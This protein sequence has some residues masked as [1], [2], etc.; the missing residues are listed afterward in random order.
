LARLSV[1]VLEDRTLLSNFVVDRLTDTGDGMGLTGDLRYCITNAVDG[2]HV[3]FADGVTGTIN[4]TGAL[5]DL[6]H[7][8]SIDGPGVASLTV[9]RDT[10][11][12]YRIFTVDSGT[13][14][15]LAGLTIANGFSYSWGGG[16]LNSG[17]LTLTNATVSGNSGAVGGGVSNTS[18]GTLTLTNVII[19][20]N[21]GDSPAVYGAGIT[22]YGTA[23]LTNATVN[24]NTGPGI[25][26]GGTVTV[27]NSTFSGNGGTGIAI[28]G[29][30]TNCTISG[31]GGAGIGLNGTVTNC[32]ISGNAGPGIAINGTV[33]DCTISGNG[34]LYLGGGG[35]VID[36][37]ATVTDCTISGNGNLYLGGGI[38]IYSGAT[39]TLNNSTVRG[40]MVGPVDDISGYG[41][42]IANWGSLTLNNSTVSGNTSLDTIN[43]E[44]AGGGIFNGGGTV[45][46]NN[47]TVSGN[48][49]L[50]NLDVSGYG[51]GIWNGA[52]T[53]TLNNSTVSGN[54]AY[55]GG[56]IFNSTR[57]SP[58]SGASG[59]AT[60]TLNNTTVSGNTG[61]IGNDGEGN[62]NATVTLLNS[63]ISGNQGPGVTNSA[64]FSD[65][66][67]TVVL[68]NSTICGNDAIGGRGAGG[69]A[70]VVYYADATVVLLNSTIAN[71]TISSSDRTGSQ[72]YSGQLAP[73][74]GQASVQLRNTLVAGSGPRPTL[75]A[76]I[77]GTFI[78]QGHNLSNDDGS[79]FLTGPGDV[80]NT[81]PL[82]GPLQDNG[83]P[84]QTMA[85]LPGSPAIDA[86]DDT[87]PLP[88]F[89]QRGPGFPR[90]SGPHIDIGAFEVQQGGDAGGLASPGGRASGRLRPDGAVR[91][92]LALS[93]RQPLSVS[94]S[95]PIAQPQGTLPGPAAASADRFF[96]ALH[97]EKSAVMSVRWSHREPGEP[98][99]WL[100]DPLREEDCL[101]V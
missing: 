57:I 91:L 63:T 60:L 64:S 30:V 62:Y 43:D 50:F 80:I 26:G 90:L 87:P 14:V 33:T 95:P 83:G 65:A 29:T 2:D 92:S 4:L 86:G 25:E 55:S 56:G 5:P 22:T 36:G 7:S 74:P 70:N 11:G 49:I 31:N 45:T 19:S 53:V 28:N 94:P 46:L 38:S 21:M 85:L 84:T 59:P 35:I 81:N 47:S 32:M 24:G 58:A 69:I 72:I 39:L 76:D 41:A 17:T 37:T 34:G 66:T 67:T 20:N 82:L 96:A 93:L 27:N 8:I 68:L 6:S 75:F 73:G 15:S 44:G 52:G 101:F 42:G 9:R 18:D 77:Q 13:T 12:Y 48:S 23:T 51:A 78:S 40:N 54:S 88:D 16:I 71:N 3:A 10:G 98:A 79:G 99:G 100:L 1:E 89:D 61:G 97:E